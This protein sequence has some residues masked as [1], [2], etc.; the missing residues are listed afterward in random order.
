MSY[1]LILIRLILIL[2]NKI[3]SAGKSDLVNIFF[4]FFR[5]HSKTVI[6]KLQCLRFRIDNDL[7]LCLIILRQR[8][9]AHHF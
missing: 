3:R 7:H 2:F 4:H 9:L 1:N 5:R 8:I 6:N